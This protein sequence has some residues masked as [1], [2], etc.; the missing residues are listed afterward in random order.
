VSANPERGGLRPVEHYTGEGE[1]EWRDEPR[2]R[3][4]YDIHR[5]QGMSAS[6]LPIPGLHR[7][8]GKLDL[9][10]VPRPAELVGEGLTLRLADGRSLRLTLEDASGRVFTEGHGP[11]RGCGCC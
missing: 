6:G 1:L 9:V 2:G 4:C 5:Y 8:E 11:S 3:V 10:A 7:I